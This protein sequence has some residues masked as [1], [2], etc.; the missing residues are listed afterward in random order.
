VESA[1]ARQA[2]VDAMQARFAR[3]E[4]IFRADGEYVVATVFQG[5]LQGEGTS[6]KPHKAFAYALEDLAAK[7]RAET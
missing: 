7:L 4:A 1:E 3:S 5:D 2:V 6:R